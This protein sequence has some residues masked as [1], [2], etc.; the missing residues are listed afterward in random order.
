MQA[1]NTVTQG[2]AEPED[3]LTTLSTRISEALLKRARFASVEYDMTMQEIVARGIELQLAEL[4]R[5][6]KKK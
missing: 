2:D 1:S 6:S 4:S 5:K 3:G